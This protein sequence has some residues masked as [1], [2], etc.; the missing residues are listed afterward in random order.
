[1]CDAVST[2]ASGSKRELEHIAAFIA[3]E[4]QQVERDGREG[5]ARRGDVALVSDNMRTAFWD[6]GGGSGTRRHRGNPLGSKG[7]CIASRHPVLPTASVMISVEVTLRSG[8]NVG[9]G[10]M[11]VV[12]CPSPLV[13]P[14]GVRRVFAQDWLA[15]PPSEL[16]QA[17]QQAGRCTWRGEPI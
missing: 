2:G 11:S 8:T 17:R 7:T 5:E 10:R 6:C 9:V 16:A 4:A 12:A 1:M 14:T 13:S 3:R 15:T